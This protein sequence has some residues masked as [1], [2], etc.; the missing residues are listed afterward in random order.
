MRLK[1][2]SGIMLCVFLAEMLLSSMVMVGVNAAPVAKLCVDIPCWVGWNNHEFVANVNITDV[3]NLYSFE[4][5]LGWNTT[6]MNLIGVEISPPTEWSTNYVVVK[7]ETVENHNAT[8]GRYWLNVSALAPA[9]SFNGSRILAKLTFKV[10]YYVV[11]DPVIENWCLLNL[12]DTNLRD[13]KGLLISH[14]VYNGSV[15]VISQ[16]PCIPFFDMWPDYYK[17]TTVGENFTVDIYLLLYNAYFWDGGWK[18]RLGYNTTLLDVI[19]VEEGPFIGRFRPADKRFFTVDIHE[20]EGYVN[21]TGGTLGTCATPYGSGTIA[22]VTFQATFAT[23][24]P[25]IAT[26]VL[27]LDA[28]LTDSEGKSGWELEAFDGLY[29]APSLPPAA[30]GGISVPVNKLSL[31]APYIGLT[32]LLAVAVIAA[33]YVRKRKR[34][35]EIIS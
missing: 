6:Y 27:D 24:L 20:E 34:H 29:E 17:A 3:E 4:F 5:K 9:P 12:Y 1:A 33:V 23:T 19:Q 7:N 30:V 8:H 35:T 28:N 25:T 18:A 16:C 11:S 22:K 31:L 13:L 10:T 32:V 14:E 2:V 26:S 21:M 15:V